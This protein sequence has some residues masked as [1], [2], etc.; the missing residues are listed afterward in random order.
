MKKVNSKVVKSIKKT[1]KNNSYNLLMYTEDSSPK[2]KRFNTLQQAQ[3]FVDKFNKKYPDHM[4]FDSGSWI[5]YL[6]TEVSGNVHFFTDGIT[7]E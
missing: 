2:I 5:D 4:S 7:V 6:V 1:E 3:D